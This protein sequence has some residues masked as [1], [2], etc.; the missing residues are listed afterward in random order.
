MLVP[1]PCYTPHFSKT[2][3]MNCDRSSR[4]LPWFCLLEPAVLLAR[5]WTHR[6][7]QV[8]R[9]PCCVELA[10]PCLRF[11]GSRSASRLCSLSPSFPIASIGLGTGRACLALTEPPTPT[12]HHSRSPAL[13]KPVWSRSRPHR[14]LC[15]WTV[16]TCWGEGWLGGAS[17]QG[18]GLL[19]NL[20]GLYF[21][22]IL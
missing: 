2:K 14:L 12:L 9:G 7:A 11:Y 21:L 13:N 4:L 5:S 22:P 16:L 18:D 19:R 15:C 17:E 8:W 10:M 1:L 3:G 6:S 20:P